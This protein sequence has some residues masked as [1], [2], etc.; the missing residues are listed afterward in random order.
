MNVRAYLTTGHSV[1]GY[2][3]PSSA[4][5]WWS[6]RAWVYVRVEGDSFTRR[7]IPTDMPASHGDGFVVPIGMFGQKNRRR[8]SP[9]LGNFYCRKSF[10]RRSMS[11]GTRLASPMS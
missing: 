2:V 7:K 9:R 11:A 10:A 4:V 8:L 5:V 3:I 6:G 1:D